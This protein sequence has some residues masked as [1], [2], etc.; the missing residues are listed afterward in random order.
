MISDFLIE[1]QPLHLFSRWLR[2]ISNQNKR[3]IFGHWQHLQKRS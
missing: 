1:I 2:H 3:Q